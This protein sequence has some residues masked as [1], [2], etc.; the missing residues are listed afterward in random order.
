MTPSSDMNRC[1]W[2]RPMARHGLSR[3]SRARRRVR[4]CVVLLY[5]IS[6][7]LTGLIVGAFA[8]LALPGRDPLTIW[9]TM[10]VGIAGSMIA[11]L[12]VYA[13]TG[14]A[15]AGGFLAALIVSIGI[16]Y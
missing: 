2:M 7:A 5:L 3:A 9:Q 10:A 15:Y 12:L 8:R 1:T 4:G 6:L 13:V 14:G 11:G 16:M